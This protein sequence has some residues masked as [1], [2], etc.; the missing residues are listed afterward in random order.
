[1]IVET[2]P[3]SWYPSIHISLEP[4]IKLRCSCLGHVCSRKVVKIAGSLH[5]AACSF[6]LLSLW[7]WY[8]GGCWRALEY[9]HFPDYRQCPF[10]RTCLRKLMLSDLTPHHKHL[11]PGTEQQAKLLVVNQIFPALV[12][13]DSSF[14]TDFTSTSPLTWSKRT[15]S[16]CVHWLSQP[17]STTSVH[18]L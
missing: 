9:E 7:S 3:V 8:S 12:Y 10:W 6:C 11:G 4:E 2:R 13:V 5:S 16:S 15:R 18:C 1:M 17:R 14:I